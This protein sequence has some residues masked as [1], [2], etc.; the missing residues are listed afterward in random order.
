MAERPSLDNVSTAFGLLSH[1][2]LTPVLV[3]LIQGSVP[4]YLAEGPLPTSDLAKRAGMDALSLTRA[5]RALAAF[6]AFEEV[7]PGVFDNNPVSDL[8]RD[9]PGCLRN[10]AP[11]WGGDHLLQCASALGHSVK[12]GEATFVHVFGESFW[13]RMRRLPEE[14][15]LFNRALADGRSDEHKQIADDYDWN[16]V[17]TAVD[18]GGDAASLL[19]AI[20]ERRP[21]KRG[22]LVEQPEVFPDADRL[23]S[24]RGVRDRC[25]FLGGSFFSPISAQGEIWTMCQV[26]HD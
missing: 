21:D 25:E 2:Y 26:L 12:T 6:G 24:E 20:L 15:A 8:F 4:D 22:V 10:T 1:L 13:E 9:R 17:N 7:S 23:L 18:V 16:G 11:F 3:T 19:A 5:L 14:H